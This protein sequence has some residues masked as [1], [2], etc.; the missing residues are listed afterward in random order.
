MFMGTAREMIGEAPW[1]L[2]VV[3]LMD[4]GDVVRKVCGYVVPALPVP[5][6]TAVVERRPLG[7]G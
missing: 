7:T 5:F 6:S 2:L 1:L 3:F 4:Q